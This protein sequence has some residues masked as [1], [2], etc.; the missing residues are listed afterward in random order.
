MRFSN[1]RTYAIPMSA[2]KNTEH[3]LRKNTDSKGKKLRDMKAKA[4]KMSG[5]DI[6]MRYLYTGIVFIVLNY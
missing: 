1:P 5:F 6:W 2:G 3:N 4:G